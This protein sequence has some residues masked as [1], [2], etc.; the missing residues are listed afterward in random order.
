MI[1]IGNYLQEMVLSGNGKPAMRS[2]D[3]DWAR[4]A[5]RTA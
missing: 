1:P 5:K 2:L 4:L 3:N